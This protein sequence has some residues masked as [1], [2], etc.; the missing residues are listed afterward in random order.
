MEKEKHGFM[1]IAFIEENKNYSN[2]LNE[3]SGI[4]Y[5]D[6]TEFDAYIDDL[7]RGR[8]CLLCF[9]KN[10]ESLLADSSEIAFFMI[11]ITG[12]FTQ[13][14]NA[15]GVR[16]DRILAGF[17]SSRK[18]GQ[19]LDTIKGWSGVWLEKS[20]PELRQKLLDKVSPMTFLDYVYMSPK[21]YDEKISML[22]KLCIQE[23][24]SFRGR[25]DN[26]ILKNY[27]NFTFMKLYDED[28][29]RQYNGTTYFN[30]GL[31]TQE[32]RKIYAV[33]KPHNQESGKMFLTGF[34]TEDKMLER[35][36]V[37]LAANDRADYFS[38]PEKL[39]LNLTMEIHPDYNHIIND[40]HDRWPSSLRGKS[41]NELV[42]ILRGAIERAKRELQA[43]YKKAVP[44]YYRPKIRGKG[45]IQ[46][47]IPLR[48]TGGD[49]DM[50]LVLE[51]KNEVYRA[52]TCLPLDWAYNNARI[53]VKPDTEWLNPDNI[54]SESQQA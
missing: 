9:G 6:Y 42:D 2:K 15:D 8:K 4:N 45:D 41:Y 14:T 31:F 38:E 48:L 7:W 46:L 32:Y 17:Y 43:N 28:K 5:D 36:G 23:S 50:A 49:V 37:S 51:R 27:L 22:A 39:I 52:S 30:T 3:L 13:S 44:Q 16:H 19:P 26:S 34:F 29:I 1:A 33:L 10:G 54:D 21:H 20:E 35:Y 53:I 40:R 47:L 25:N 18:T 12:F 11:D 24:W